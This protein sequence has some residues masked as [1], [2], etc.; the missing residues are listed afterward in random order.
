VSKLLSMRCVVLL[1]QVVSA[2][3][4]ASLP[5][6]QQWQLHSQC[7]WCGVCSCL[8]QLQTYQ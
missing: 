5:H 4:D 1:C 8:C 6:T 3:H 2:G 7:H